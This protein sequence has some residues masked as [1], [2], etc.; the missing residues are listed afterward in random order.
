MTGIESM[1]TVV[2]RRQELELLS[3]LLAAAAAGRPQL[4]V[5]RGATGMGKS[6]L[7]QRILEQNPVVPVF[8]GSGA[9]W[10]SSLEGGV[11]RQILAGAAA[12]DPGVLEGPEAGRV[13]LA[14]LRE[15]RGGVPAVLLVD[16]LHWVD[17][18]T[19]RALLFAVRRLT[20][21]KLMVIVTLADEEAHRLPPECRDLLEDR[22]AT[23]L[24]AEPMK[25][26]D[27]RDLAAR[28]I[29][30]DLSLPAAHRLAVHVGGNPREILQL[31][32]EN[33]PELWHQ[34]QRELP[35]S[36]SLTHDM[37]RR[38]ASVRDETRRLV[39]AAAVLGP[40]AGLADAAAL[41]DI[42][43]PL[44]AV[45]EAARFGFLS[46]SGD[47]GNLAVVF[48][49]PVQRTAAYQTLPWPR[50]ISM[51]LAAASLI[52][53]EGA[54][55]GHRAAASLLPDP[56]LAGELEA[57]AAGQ[58]DAGAWSNA[59][60][61][62]FKSGQLLPTTECR[63]TRLLRA[64]DAMVGAGELPRALT[65][66][67]EISNFSASPLRDAVSGYMAILQG[68]QDHADT[69][70]DQAWRHSD[71]V[72]DPQTVA[73]IAQRRVLDSLA[74]WNG[75]ELLSWVS[76]AGS[77]A[78][79]GSPAFIESQA[80]KGLGLAAT[81]HTA[82]AEASYAALLEH[83][84]LGAQKQRVQM[85]MG[86]L[87]VATDRVGAARE[88]LSSAVSTHFNAGS[89]RISLWARAW[90]ARAEFAAGSWDQALRTIDSGV[91]LQER[92]GMEL[93]R[94]LLHWT[95][96]QIHALR[97]NWAAAAEHLDRGRASAENYP[98]M[99]LPYLLARAH[100]A[101]AQADYDG[102]LQ[103][104]EPLLRLD[105]GNGIDEPGFWPWHDVYA[106]ALVM[107]DRG[108]EAADF[109][110]PLEALV[111]ARGHRS[112]SARLGYVRGRLL[113]AEG[114]IEGAKDAFERGLLQLDGLHLPFDRAQVDFA[115][116]QTLRRA[117][118]R[119][120]AAVP[121]TRA[122]DAFR[123]L[124]AREYVERCERELQASG[125]NVARSNIADLS[126]LT[127]QETAVAKRVADGATNK[128]VAEE[129]YI[130][131]KT[132]QYHLTHTY[133]KLGVRS[134]TELAAHYRE[135]SSPEQYPD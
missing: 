72:A 123:A 105:R 120:D 122:L 9:A 15:A 36:K 60:D 22:L 75:A 86:W 27:I 31:L 43:E 45:D 3:G 129:L 52:D 56:Q 99:R 12:V 92:V 134:R 90:L 112:A 118:K 100:V 109:L 82:E 119:R 131:V 126:A 18:A 37:A 78:D 16:K 50:R 34:W 91:V 73:M 46:V 17:V 19:L 76:R 106:N 40:A 124:A 51:H 35:A 108:R 101:E 95:A 65:Y 7:V 14:A 38:L 128:Q 24:T 4:A 117:G 5:I 102:V 20:C 63:E 59:A 10:E 41:A 13:L 125:M 67:A 2:G 81:G 84:G 53:N 70:L 85:G 8:R 61:A 114:D 97:G 49:N 57:Y 87:H 69:L 64:I 23:T 93:V 21:E 30:A 89:F 98:V 132:V 121:L 55:L 74:R 133:A 77:L 79:E 32:R 116:G 25:A 80:I 42:A 88:E 6:F 71:P 44:A 111:A 68:R 115:Y 39:E 107:K 66:A 58:A 48:V 130:S 29:G 83:E 110:V 54:A 33:P 94:P 28:A 127:A 11:L 62:L 47:G 104:L 103:A 135:A 26:A 1:P 96:T 113:G